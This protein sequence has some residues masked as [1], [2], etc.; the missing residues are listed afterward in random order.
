MNHRIIRLIVRK[1]FKKAREEYATHTENA[2]TEY[3]SRK[4][5]QVSSTTLKRT[6]KKYVLKDKIDINPSKHTINELC[7]YIEYNDY[8]NF[9]KKTRPKRLTYLISKIVTAIVLPLLILF[10][11]KKDQAIIKDSNYKCMAWVEDHYEKV[12]C[13]LNFHP[14]SGRKIEPFETKKL[15]NFRKVEVTILTKFFADEA[16]KQPLIWYYKNK[17][18]EIEY[19]TAP[20]LHPTTGKTLDEITPYIIEKYVPKHNFKPDSFISTDKVIKD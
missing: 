16:K 15:S 18:G 1:A 11:I 13:D 19:F 2:L 10:L 9:V 17:K 3:V 5:D 6:Y 8:G 12:S 7:K 20:G 14:K 4:L